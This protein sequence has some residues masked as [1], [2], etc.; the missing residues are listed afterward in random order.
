MKKTL[1]LSA[2]LGAALCGSAYAAEYTINVDSE[3]EI[4]FNNGSNQHLSASQAGDIITLNVTLPTSDKGGFFENVGEGGTATI[5]ANLV[6]NSLEF[7][8]G[9]SRNSGLT[10]KFTGDVSGSGNIT[11]GSRQKGNNFV[12]TGDLSEYTGAITF[13]T[14]AG[15]APVN[16]L[17]FDASAREGGMTVGASSITM[18]NNAKLATVGNVTF[19]GDVTSANTSIGAG[20]TTL[21]TGKTT[22]LSSVTT[23]DDGG[24]LMVS[25][26]ATLNLSGTVNALTDN[27]TENLPTVSNGYS[28]M[29]ASVEAIAGS[30]TVNVDNVTAWQVNGNAATYDNGTL[31]LSGESTKY[32]VIESAELS[33]ALD[34]KTTDVTIQNGATLNI[35]SHTTRQ[36]GMIKGNVVVKE[37]STLKLSANDALGWSGGNHVSTLTVESGAEVNM[38]NAGNET[39]G[40]TLNLNGSLTGIEGSKWDMFS[41]STLNVGANAQAEISVSELRLR[42]NGVTISMGN[43]S[44]LDLSAAI[45][46]PYANESDGVLTV[47]GNGTLNLTGGADIDTLTIRKGGDTNISGK[48]VTVSKYYVGGGTTNLSAT[49][50][51]GQV[52]LDENGTGTLKIKE[53]GVLNVTGTSNDHST[54]ASLI[55]NHWGH[56]GTMVLDGGT[57]NATGAE[58][59][60]SWDGTGIFQANAGTANL[61]GISAWSHSGIKGT[62]ELGT[63]TE[64]S[65]KVIIGANGL[66]DFANGSTLKL[67]NGTLGASDDWT[68]RYNTDLTQT[69]AQFIATTETGTI[70][71]TTKVGTEGE[72]ATIT[73]K[74]GT[75]GVGNMTVQGT[76]S[77]VL[78][79]ASDRTGTTT[80]NSGT[81]QVKEGTALG[82]GSVVLN[83]GS[84]QVDTDATIATLTQNGGTIVVAEGSTLTVTTLSIAETATLAVQGAIEFTAPQNI[85][86]D[87]I[88]L[89]GT[90]ITLGEDHSGVLTTSAL[91]VNSDSTVNANLVIA[92]GGSIT[93]TEGTVTL[94]CTIDFGTGTTIALGEAYHDQLKTNGMALIFT[95]VDDVHGLE[96]VVVTGDFV[97]G[98]LVKV[99]Q[100]DGSYNIYATPEPATATLSLLALAG[101][102]ARRRRH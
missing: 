73:F 59:H 43:N 66:S 34:S 62:F 31:N 17:T 101:L 63:A 8:N 98:S 24:K 64:G 16:S 7:N 18:Q 47:T 23:I 25:E 9:Y 11:R 77:L 51:A 85:T 33:T 32:Y 48:D 41:N 54:N 3:T 80:I 67:G 22:A 19:K 40:G 37:G 44:T 12:F 57:L 81:L 89:D 102:M 14:T 93:F 15:A 6:I 82:T 5:A 86:H 45:K 69:K 87:S 39:F 95:G 50:N 36:D 72:G 55:L 26:G 27:F 38:N 76:G 58:M 2:I 53:G 91:T 79:G 96:N 13:N 92:D 83:D 49:M 10:Y 56:T 84:L 61:L 4:M 88:T 21:A 97:P 100:L 74:N 68:L 42:R 28:L 94:G 70:I 75:T 35:T 60:L 78:E 1:F 71:D 99:Q 46:R 90:T 20:T 52:R 65:A 29:E 30:G